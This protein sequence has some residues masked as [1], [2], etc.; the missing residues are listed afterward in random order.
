MEM[1]LNQNQQIDSALADYMK[2]SKNETIDSIHEEELE[3]ITEENDINEEH[4]V[5]EGG[6]GEPN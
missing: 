6:D 1:S 4:D 5:M 2:F 3:K